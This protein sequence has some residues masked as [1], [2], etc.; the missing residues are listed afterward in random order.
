LVI[1]GTS[2]RLTDLVK[3][4]RQSPSAPNCKAQGSG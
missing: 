2:S 1:T 3:P 4:I